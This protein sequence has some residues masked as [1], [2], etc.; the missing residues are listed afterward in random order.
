MGLR[1]KKISKES[2]EIIKL[3]ESGLRKFEVAK[4][5]YSLSTIRY[6][7][8]KIY[9]NKAHTRFVSQIHSYNK[10]RLGALDKNK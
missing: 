5:G 10:A 2:Q 6:Y 4:K 8:R 3:L 9:D 7:Y 1:G